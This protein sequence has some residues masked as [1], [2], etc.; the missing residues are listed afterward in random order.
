MSAKPTNKAL[1]IIVIVLLALTAVF[2]L[3][4]GIGT[5]CVAFNPLGSSASM[6]KLAPVQPIF[7]VLVI[8]SVAA[9]L[10]GIAAAVRLARGQ[11]SAYNWSLIFLIIGGAASAIQFYYSLTLRGSTAPNSFRLY[12]TL[13]TLV[14]FL[15]L[16][17]PGIWQKAGFEAGQN[18]G[19]GGTAAGLAMILCGLMTLSL[20]VW[21]GPTHIVDGFNTVN[22]LLVPLMA[23]GSALTIAGVIKLLPVQLTHKAAVPTQNRKDLS[24]IEG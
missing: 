23:V 15:V 8:V 1:R 24:S 18:S 13:L 10:F 20:P 7:I 22:L 14:I 6:A 17:L 2:T 21:G 11:R 5:A 19:S 4:G 12:L 9:G 16:R 3:L